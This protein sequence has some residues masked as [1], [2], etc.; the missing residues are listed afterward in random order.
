MALTFLKI[1]NLRNLLDVELEPGPGLNV[2]LGRNG[3]GKTS[4]LEAIYILSRGR[5]F[6]S[7][8]AGPVISKG[9]SSLEVFARFDMASSVK[10]VGV[11]KGKGGTEIRLN[12]EPV[13]QLSKLARAVPQL[14]ITPKS[15]EILERGP[16]YRRRFMDWGVFH[17]EHD[18][19]AAAKNYRRVLR[20]RNEALKRSPGQL[21][22]WDL[23]LVKSGL[24]VDR[25]RKGYVEALGKRFFQYIRNFLP[26]SEISLTYTVTANTEREYLERLHK[27]RD[28][29]LRCG[30]TF[31]GPHRADLKVKFEGRDAEKVVSRG[32]QKLILAALFLSQAELVARQAMAKPI[33]LVDDL[34]AEL[35]RSNRAIFLEELK[36]LNTQV[37]I[38]GTETTLF[39]GLDELRVFHV[40]QGTIS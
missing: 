10:K 11:R 18:F 6:R 35:D 13:K 30:Y 7:D 31:V 23:E 4:V 27:H 8:R 17:V 25:C 20:Q 28:E 40:E 34:P 36:R 39:D 33:L 24:R 38:T 21:E 22:S 12:G 32:E 9:E 1:R 2:L 37:M 16:E 5:S 26:N 15:H 29:E 14:L 3:A 19:L